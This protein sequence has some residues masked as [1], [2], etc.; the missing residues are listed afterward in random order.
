MRPPKGSRQV[1]K[2]LAASTTQKSTCLVAIIVRTNTQNTKS[3]SERNGDCTESVWT[4]RNADALSLRRCQHWCSLQ[5]LLINIVH[6]NLHLAA[7]RWMWYVKLYRCQKKKNKCVIIYLDF[8]KKFHTTIASEFHN[9]FRWC[10][11]HKSETMYSSRS[12]HNWGIKISASPSSKS[13]K[14]EM[15]LAQESR[16]SMN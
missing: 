9:F 13:N 3:I 5:D 15:L 12:S 8:R 1:R 10:T 4:H 11:A 2:R 7:E 6:S 14:H 16:V